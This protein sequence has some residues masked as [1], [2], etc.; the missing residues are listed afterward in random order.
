MHF[1]F[2]DMPYTVK[3]KFGVNSRKKF[4]G[5]ILH[6]ARCTMKVRKT[7]FLIAVKVLRRVQTSFAVNLKKNF[8]VQF[9]TVHPNCTKMA[10]L[11]HQY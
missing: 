1:G 3:S 7:T 6:G 2:F 4:F 10:K 5:A 11:V 8:L 9:S